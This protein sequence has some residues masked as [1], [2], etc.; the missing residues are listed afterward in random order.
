MK[1]L[2]EKDCKKTQPDPFMF[3]TDGK[4][5]MY[6]TA[7]RGVEAYTADTPFSE[8]HY[9]GIVCTVDG[10]KDYWAPCIIEA[11]GWYYLY[12][13]C[14]KPGMFE[15]LH[16]S[17]SRSPLGPFGETKCLFD[18]FSID[19]HV[20]RTAAGLFLFYAEDNRKPERIG[21][22]IFVDKLIDPYTPAYQPVEVVVPTFDEEIFKRNRFGDGKD[23]HTIE[24]P[25]WLEVDGWQ[26]LMYSGACYENDTYHIGYAAAHT[27]EPD[28]TKVKFEKH[29]ANGKFDPLMI[30][31]DFEEGVGHHS[32]IQYNGEYYAIFHGR[33]LT[34]GDGERRTAR[35][36]R[37]R[38]KDGI[39]TAER[40]ADKL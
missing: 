3:E 18:R 8:W 24:G 15:Y 25:F 34:K 5:Y 31:N 11:D 30:K 16:V 37:L 21:T 9:A 36:C 19:A 1:L 23:W 35:A 2:F 40:F 38:F 39:I 26:Y 29:T 14:S 12:Y 13:S 6:V 27:D 28:L 22:R 32:V 7:G 17:R 33:D 10:C 4:Y 20:V